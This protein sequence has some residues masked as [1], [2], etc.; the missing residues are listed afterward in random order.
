M[1]YDERAFGVCPFKD[2]DVA[3]M[4]A[5][6]EWVAFDIGGGEVR[7]GGADFGRGRV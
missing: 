6:F 5:E 2:D 1:F 3:F 4:V 7:C